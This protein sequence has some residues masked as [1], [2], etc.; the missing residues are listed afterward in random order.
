VNST[1]LELIHEL[2]MKLYE[3]VNRHFKIL[4]FQE[5]KGVVGVSYMGLN[6]RVG[7]PAR[8]S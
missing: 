5:A 6:E 8:P 4:T 7:N 3:E 1:E 2:F